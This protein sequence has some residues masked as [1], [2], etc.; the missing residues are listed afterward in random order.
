MESPHTK[1]INIFNDL[2]YMARAYKNIA[3]LV[4]YELDLSMLLKK[5]SD[6][7]LN[8]PRVTREASGTSGMSA[9]MNGTV[10]LSIA[11]GWHPEFCNEGVNAFTIPTE[12]REL[13]T[14]E[15]DSLD[16]KNLMDTLEDRII[17]LYYDNH[18]QWIEIMKN[19]IN[20]VSP[21][22]ESGRMADEYYTKMYTI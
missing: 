1:A 13:P 14:H 22:F 11:D 4:G 20:D 9:A 16:N 3:V 19:A 17:P 5:G 2:N 8:T 15:E 6:V 10:N 12:G 21:A 7:W 18:D